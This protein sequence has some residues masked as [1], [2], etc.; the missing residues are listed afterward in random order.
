MQKKL[1]SLI[2]RFWVVIEYFVNFPLT[3]RG[4]QD[5]M[6]TQLAVKSAFSRL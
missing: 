6:G 2:E 5:K 3:G 4:G 1:I